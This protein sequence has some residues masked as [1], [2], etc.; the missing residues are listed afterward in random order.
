MRLAV[1]LIATI[2]GAIVLIPPDPPVG[3]LLWVGLVMGGLIY[4]A[5]R[6]TDGVE[7]LCPHSDC[8]STR[9]V[10]WW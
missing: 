10:F 9:H 6:P 1:F 2:I 5:H 4:L 8:D 3:I 7:D